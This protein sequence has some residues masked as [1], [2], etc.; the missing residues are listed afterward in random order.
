MKTLREIA[1]V[2][3]LPQPT[4]AAKPSLLDKAFRYHKAETH[5]TPDAFR[6]RMNK[7]AQRPTWS[8]HAN[9]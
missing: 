1:A 8:N 5:S 7:Y 2:A 4:H 3:T 9:K 6:E